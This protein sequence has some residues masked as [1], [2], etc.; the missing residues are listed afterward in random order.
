MGV[1]YLARDLRLGRPAPVKPP[2]PRRAPR[3]P[4]AGET[5]PVTVTAAPLFPDL[6][7]A[8]AGRYVLERR[9]GRGGRGVV[10]L[11]RELRL[12]RRVAIKLPPPERAP[13]ATERQRFIAPRRSSR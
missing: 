7:R 3:V 2:P 4:P 5:G 10:S 12:A 13:Q 9:R 6:Q 1:V 11:A 8:L